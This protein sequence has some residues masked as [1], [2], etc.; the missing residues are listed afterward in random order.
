MVNFD[1]RVSLSK[2][3]SQQ[4]TKLQNLK[5]FLIKGPDIV[6]YNKFRFFFPPPQKTCA[7][8]PE[9]DAGAAEHTPLSDQSAGTETHENYPRRS[10]AHHN[11]V[12]VK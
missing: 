6:Q 2:K 4:D 8:S 11:G 7:R 3:Y 9:G 5:T 12:C 10:A 1:S